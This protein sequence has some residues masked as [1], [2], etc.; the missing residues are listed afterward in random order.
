MKWTRFV[1]TGLV[2]I[3]CMFMVLLGHSSFTTSAANPVHTSP[4]PSITKTTTKLA[5]VKV[6][7]VV[8]LIEENHSYSQIIGKKSA[9]YLNSLVKRG[10]LFT[11]SY[12]IQHPSQPNYLALFSGSTQNV[13]D[14]SC[15]H[16]FSAPNLATELRKA[17]LSF[18]GYSEDMP[19]VGYTGCSYKGY[20]RKHNPW[21]N[22]TNVPANANMP[23]QS[24]PTDFSKLP[25][26]S[27]IIPNHQND[28]HDGTIEQADV[29]LKKHANSYLEWAAKH[30]SLLIITWDEDDFSPRN[31]IP[32]LMIGPMVKP[33]QYPEKINHYSVLRTIEDIYRLGHLGESAKANPIVSIWK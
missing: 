10:A 30:N 26:V 17:H 33:G 23:L 20:A 21:V 5:D 2:C 9:P 3:T 28:M 22:F 8:I 15:K 18:G 29:W 6:E 11:N 12:G 14:D 27:F 4:A 32:T 16:V 7:H 25:T 24:L 13:K 1:R 31:H 19:G